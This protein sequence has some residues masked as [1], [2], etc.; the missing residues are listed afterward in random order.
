MEIT[1][2]TVLASADELLDFG[3]RALAAVGVDDLGANDMTTQILNSELA[4][5]ESHGF[6]RLK[7]Y[8]QRALDGHAAPTTSGIIESDTGSVVTIDG[9]AG[10]GH[11]VMR[12]ASRVA[13]TRAKDHGIAAVTVRNSEPAGRFADFCEEAAASGVATLVFVNCGGAAQVAGPP[14]S[15]EPR[16]GTNPIAAGVPREQAP[17]L[18][19]DM[20]TTA[21]AMGRVSEW[22]DRDLPVPPEWV[23]EAG[24]L[25]F[26]AGAKGFA[27]AL[28][29]EALGGALSGAGTVSTEAG[30]DRQ[31]VLMIAIDVARFRP[32]LDFTTDVERVAEYVRHAPLEAGAAPIRMPG[33]STAATARERRTSG[34]PVQ[35]FTWASL[36]EIAGLLGIEPPQ[37]KSDKDF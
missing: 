18:V 7:E 1:T 37:H 27:L 14:G 2:E 32:L 11:L 8:V 22:R 26:M 29:A 13:V 16:L 24:V 23:N 15:L 12:H 25:Q 6:R 31:G 28:I 34:V 20:A 5:H 35:P 10:Y 19:I 17:H 4:G 30:V 21:V 33:E 3:R 36:H 9:Q